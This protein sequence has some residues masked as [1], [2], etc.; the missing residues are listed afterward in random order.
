MAAV[1]IT[2]PAA[3]LILTMLAASEA[4][5]LRPAA[6]AIFCGK[7]EVSAKSSIL[8][9]AVSVS[10]TVTADGGGDGGDGGAA[11]GSDGGS[12]SDG[13]GSGQA[14]L[15]VQAAVVPSQRHGCSA[16]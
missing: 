3:T 10:T 13:G 2:L 8:P 14:P 5:T 4:V 7:L 12:G 6:V 16:S 1:M 15:E 9:L 11:G